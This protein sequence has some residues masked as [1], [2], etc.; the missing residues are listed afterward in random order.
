M[1]AGGVVVGGE[2]VKPNRTRKLVPSCS[3]H[4]APLYLP[5]A[6][7]DKTSDPPGMEHDSYVTQKGGSI[8]KRGEGGSQHRRVEGG[9]LDRRVAA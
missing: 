4:V 8:D 9:S 6:K 2:D 3:Y 5:F 1:V 7:S